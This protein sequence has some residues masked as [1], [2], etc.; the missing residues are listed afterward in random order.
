[1]RGHR[2]AQSPGNNPGPADPA[3]TLLRDI[4]S[5]GTL[6]R[7]FG[8]V[9]APMHTKPL[10]E[11]DSSELKTVRQ[12]L[13]SLRDEE[14]QTK[15]PR[16]SGDPPGPVTLRNGITRARTRPRISAES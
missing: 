1:M 2:C 16:P 14:R 3:R 8:F 6:S 13:T 9:P 15:A 5:R 7:P 11:I 10:P 4:V 12:F